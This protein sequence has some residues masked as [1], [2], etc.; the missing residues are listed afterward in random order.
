VSMGIGMGIGMG[1]LPLACLHPTPYT[2]HHTP[3]TL[4]TLSIYIYITIP[5]TQQPV[6]VLEHASELLHVPPLYM[7]PIQRQR[8]KTTSVHSVDL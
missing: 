8:N 1:M 2:L 3:Y 4:H 5:L 7:I 6:V